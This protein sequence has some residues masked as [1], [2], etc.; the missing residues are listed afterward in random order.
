MVLQTLRATFI[1]ALSLIIPSGTV[2][3]V[4]DTVEEHFEV[5]SYR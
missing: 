2:S 1:M 4:I 5:L 3:C